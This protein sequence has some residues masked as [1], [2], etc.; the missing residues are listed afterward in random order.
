MLIRSIIITTNYAPQ[1][2]G[3]YDV[4]EHHQLTILVT[5]TKKKRKEKRKV[6]IFQFIDFM[7]LH[8]PL[9]GI[10]APAAA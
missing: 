9:S 7:L 4:T 2:F 5:P 10:H 1:R 8:I 6:L 3:I